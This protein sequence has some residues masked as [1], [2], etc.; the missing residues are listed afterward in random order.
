ML[1]VFIFNLLETNLMIYLSR[2]SRLF[3]DSAS[4]VFN[5]IDSWLSWNSNG[6]IPQSTLLPYGMHD[7]WLGNESVKDLGV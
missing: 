6:T 3:V 5:S 4:F 1:K 7:V 2:I